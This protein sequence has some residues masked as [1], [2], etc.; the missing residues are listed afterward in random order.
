[1]NEINNLVKKVFDTGLSSYFRQ[2]AIRQLG[3]IKKSVALTQAIL[4]LLQDVKEEPLQR[5]VMDLSAK[6]AIGESVNFIIPISGGS[7]QNARHAINVLAKIGGR[8]AYDS[9]KKTADMPGFDL[10]KTAAVR[11]MQDMLRRQPELEFPEPE[12]KAVE[13]APQEK[14]IFASMTE[15]AKEFTEDT[16]KAVTSIPEKVS[17]LATDI[18][19]NV[20]NKVSEAAASVAINT[21]TNQEKRA[22]FLEDKKQLAAL[23]TELNKYTR[24]I[25]ER[26]TTIARLNDEISTLKK[27]PP[28]QSPNNDALKMIQQLKGDKARLKAGYEKKIVLQEKKIQSLE[29][30]VESTQRRSRRK[31]PKKSAPGCGTII[32]TIFAIFMAIKVLEKIF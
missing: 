4:K 24:Y 8:Q 6:M 29:D 14:S 23:S 21:P 3:R 32:L 9:L 28:V 16:V 10:K 19:K 30:Q 31:T 27:A 26:D 20:Q 22:Q 18:Q 1:M 17:E 2:D 15:E 7:S 11:G 13:Q 12:V 25:T 5:E